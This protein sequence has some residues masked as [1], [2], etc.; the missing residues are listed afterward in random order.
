MKEA[1]PTETER[2]LKKNL[3]K[4]RRGSSSTQ[5]MMERRERKKYVMKV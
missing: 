4:G 2:K 5:R 3:L 1:K